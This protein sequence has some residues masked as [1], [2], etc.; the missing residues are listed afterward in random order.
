MAKN[1]KKSEDVEEKEVSA[2]TE[3]TKETEE[4]TA[5]E[6]AKPNALSTIGEGDEAFLSLYGSAVERVSVEL[7]TPAA[8]QEIID[9]LPEGYIDDLMGIIQ[10]TMGA[11]KGVYGDSDRPDFPELRI[12]H[13]VGNDPNRPDKQIPGEYYLTTKET[14][15]EK[16]EGAVLAM[17]GGR[18]MW[19]D[20]EAGESTSMPT[21]QSMDRK[22][23]STCGTC[24]TCPH[25]PWRDGQ[26][27]RC[28]DDVVAFMLSRDM[29]EIVLVRFQKT[30]EPAGRQLKKFVKRSMQPWSKWFQITSESRTSK[31][32]S[33]RRWYVMKVEPA[34]EPTVPAEIHDFCDAMCTSLEATY[35]LPNIA[36]IYRSGQLDDVPDTGAGS[37]GLMSDP[38]ATDDADLNDIDNVPSNV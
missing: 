13:G 25:L 16:F 18:T 27:Q 34:K 21:C 9:G 23:G 20:A 31:Q 37:V 29:K 6:K 5:I 1:P 30:S 32:D 22:M 10:K 14:V 26:H 15:G 2:A 17:W 24:E 36:S 3:E 35:I 38:V 12:Y 33:N 28:A 19:G 7:P 8:F 11:R 4:S